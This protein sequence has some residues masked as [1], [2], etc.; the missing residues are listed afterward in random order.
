MQWVANK[1]ALLFN[2]SSWPK[3]MDF[4]RVI[5]AMEEQ[6]SEYGRIAWRTY[7]GRTTVFTIALHLQAN[8]WVRRSKYHDN[9]SWASST[10]MQSTTPSRFFTIAVLLRDAH[11]Q[12]FLSWEKEIYLYG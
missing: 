10:T 5:T 1:L 8:L 11:R 4:P 3:T 7:L 2:T 12:V 9:K 6:S